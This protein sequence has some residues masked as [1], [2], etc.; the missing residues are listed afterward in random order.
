MKL[1]LL[2]ATVTFLATGAIA[3]H[4]NHNDSNAETGQSQFAAIAEIVTM[5]RDDPDTHWAMVDIDALRE[6]LVDMDNVTTKAMV[7]TTV[8]DLTV[9]FSVTG[10]DP[11]AGSIKRMVL[12]HSPML[13]QSLGWT[14]VAEEQADGAIMKVQLDSIDNLDEVTGLGFFGLMTIGAHHQQHHL[15]IAKGHSPH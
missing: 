9:T 13:Q 15:M 1:S 2:T 12:A 10:T 11:I 4:T 8:K 7:E 3:Q 5:L 6:H 14:V